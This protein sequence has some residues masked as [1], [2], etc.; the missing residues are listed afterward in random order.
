M[1]KLKIFKN[2]MF[3]VSIQLENGEILFDAENVAVCLGFTE[4]KNEKEYVRWRTV[5]KYIKPFYTRAE[6]INSQKVAKG[7]FIPES[8]V[9]K[10]AFKANNEVAE[11]F[12]DWLAIDVIPQIRKHGMYAKDE[13]LDNPDLLFDV[14]KKYKQ[15]REEKLALQQKVI[16]D[17]PKV[18]FAKAVENSNDVILVKEMA[19]ILTQNGF[20]IGQNQ[21]YLYLRNNEFLCKR[22]GD[23][24]HLP[25]KKYEHLFKVIKR[26]IQNSE[27]TRV[28]NTPKINGKGQMYFIKKFEKYKENGLTINDLLNQQEVI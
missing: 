18:D 24:Y 15:E 23:M 25:T 28:K 8:L 6:D 19:T 26:T 22:P 17:K 20:K 7:D 14:V 4:V 10:L 11:K 3:K 13:L 1:N 27:G 9:Y 21:L 16:E 12:Q 5:N 2:K